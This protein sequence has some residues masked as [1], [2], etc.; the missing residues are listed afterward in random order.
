MKNCEIQKNKKKERKTETKNRLHQKTLTKADRQYLV[1]NPHYLFPL[2]DK[3]YS[4]DCMRSAEKKDREED[5]EK[6]SDTSNPC[7]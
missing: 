3:H 7:N 4:L 2:D 5:R 1:Q 6:G